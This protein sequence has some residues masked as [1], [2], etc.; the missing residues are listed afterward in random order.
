[1]LSRK[2]VQ[3]RIFQETE[4][5]FMEA[6]NEETCPSPHCQS[7]GN[8]KQLLIQENP[9]N[10]PAYPAKYHYFVCY[11]ING[12]ADFNPQEANPK[13]NNEQEDKGV[14]KKIFIS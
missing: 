7:F 8:I 5:R 9:P 3:I 1:M 13:T 11:A 4:Q 14:D 6:K 2:Y 10:A 12:M